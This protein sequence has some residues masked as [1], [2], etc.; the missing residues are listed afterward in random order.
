VKSIYLSLFFILSLQ[1]QD[2]TVLSS[3]EILTQA[4]ESALSVLK[5]EITIEKVAAEN[6]ILWPAPETQSIADT[7]KLVAA[8]AE[9]EY[10]KK[11]DAKS[12]ADFT[13]QAQAYYAPYEKGTKITIYKTKALGSNPRVEGKFY[14]IDSYGLIKIGSLRVPV[15]DISKRDVA[16]FFPE[17]ATQLIK[18]YAN[19]LEHDYNFKKKNLI[20]G[21]KD[22]IRKEIYLKHGLSLYRNKWMPTKT[23]VE[24]LRK[25]AIQIA[26]PVKRKEIATGIYKENG[27]QLTANKWKH[28]KISFNPSNFDYTPNELS[29][30]DLENLMSSKNISI[31]NS[32]LAK[33]PGAK[34]YDFEF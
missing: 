24:G 34:Y 8:A 11:H 10:A 19:G 27:Y 2:N 20:T 21:I 9:K 31:S 26:L 3:Q 15:I 23:L 29:L 32:P 1:A 13:K 6:K 16:R 28:P 33:H 30:V 17:K 14:G 5:D 18:N 22:S 7:E 25:Q 4:R 12:S